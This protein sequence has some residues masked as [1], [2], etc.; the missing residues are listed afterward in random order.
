[1][2]RN[3]SCKTGTFH[4]CEKNNKLIV[5]IGEKAFSKKRVYIAELGISAD[6]VGRVPRA[7]PRWEVQQLQKNVMK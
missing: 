4:F 1:M 7:S 5:L 2:K 6:T 3:R